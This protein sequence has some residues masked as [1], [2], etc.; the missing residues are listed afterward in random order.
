MNKDTYI[1]ISRSGGGKGTQVALLEAYLKDKDANQ[2]FHLEAGDR[3]REFIS[4][5][6]YSGHLAKINNDKGNLQPSFL[7]IWAWGGEL[8]SGVREDQIL[9]V[10]GT[11]RQLDEALILDEALKFYGRKEVTVVHIN[12]S[13]EWAISRM[14]ERKRADDKDIDS[15]NRRLDWFDTDVMKVLDYFEKSENYDIVEINGEQDIKSVHD[16]IIEKLK[17]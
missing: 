7:A 3:F 13:R 15:I 5:D 11:P 10:D 12:V 8:I 17:V 9:I 4:R 1:F 2:V 14:K 16:E 6:T